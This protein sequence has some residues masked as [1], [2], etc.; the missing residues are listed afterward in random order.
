MQGLVLPGVG[1]TSA[2][3]ELACGEFIELVE[4]VVLVAT[5]LVVIGAAAG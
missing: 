1:A 4:A 3:P 2:R 5:V